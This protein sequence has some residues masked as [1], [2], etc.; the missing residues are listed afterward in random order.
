[1]SVRPDAFVI[2]EDEALDP[3]VTRTVARL[4]AGIES[5]AWR[6]RGGK[7]WDADRY[8]VPPMHARRSYKATRKRDKLVK[9]AMKA[10]ARNVVV[11]ESEEACTVRDL[12]TGKERGV[13]LEELG[14]AIERREA[15]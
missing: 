12:G 13:G 10:G 4:R 8:A 5:D 7:P 6:D 1:V 11:V 3:V 14:A 15:P 2:A 9:D